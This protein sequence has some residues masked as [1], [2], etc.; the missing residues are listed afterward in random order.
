EVPPE[1]VQKVMRLEENVKVQRSV[2]VRSF[3]GTP[4]MVLTVYT[5]EHIGRC[6]L[7]QDVENEALVR[8]LRRNAN[9]VAA[10]QY[11]S[12]ALANAQI[13][14]SLNI[15]VGSALTHLTSII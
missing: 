3:N 4:F 12:S 9:F 11:F 15:P 7:R 8:L 1:P 10:E 5:P 6:F 13:A 14:T 2:R